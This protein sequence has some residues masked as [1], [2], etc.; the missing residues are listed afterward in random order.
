MPHFVRGVRLNFSPRRLH[1][2]WC[3]HCQQDVPAARDSSGPAACSRCQQEFVALPGGSRPALKLAAIA[4]Y[5]VALEEFDLAAQQAT[6]L[7]RPKLAGGEEDL[8]RL[9]RLL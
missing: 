7:V 1:A 6:S 3:R 2:M 5:G 9:E 4:D 8:R